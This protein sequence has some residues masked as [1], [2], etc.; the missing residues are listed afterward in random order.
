MGR[1]Q[2]VQ[3]E[4]RIATIVVVSGQEEVQRQTVPIV[5]LKPNRESLGESFTNHNI[6]AACGSVS[7]HLNTAGKPL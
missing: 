4:L 2:T 5:G 1:A 3:C 7:S 6:L